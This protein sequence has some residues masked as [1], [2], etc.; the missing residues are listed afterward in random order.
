MLAQLST[1]LQVVYDQVLSHVPHEQRV[2]I[3]GVDAQRRRHEPHELRLT[4]RV[5]RRR[6]HQPAARG[7]P[8]VDL[9]RGKVTS[10]GAPPSRIIEL[11]S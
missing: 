6:A 2:W 3:E 11:E 9:V 8:D 1:A 7:Q 4:L 10:A 5:T